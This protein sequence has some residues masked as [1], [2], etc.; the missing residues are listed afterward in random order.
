MFGFCTLKTRCRIAR[1][2]IRK[3]NAK[4]DEEIDIALSLDG[5]GELSGVIYQHFADSAEAEVN[6]ILKKLKL[7]RSAYEKYLRKALM[8]EAHF[9][10]DVPEAW[11][12]I[13]I[14]ERP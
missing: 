5:S 3:Y 12:D 1:K 4:R 8:M 2:L 6:I 9:G 13:L 11:L 14:V 7:T 10:H